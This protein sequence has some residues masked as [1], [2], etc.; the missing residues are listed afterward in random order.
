[1]GVFILMT[2]EVMSMCRYLIK[3]MESEEEINGK[4]LLKKIRGLM[5]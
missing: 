2:S 1:M 4:D 3:D 5:I